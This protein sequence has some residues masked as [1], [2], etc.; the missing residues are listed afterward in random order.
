[1]NGFRRFFNKS[2]KE[3]ES[4]DSTLAELI[5]KERMMGHETGLIPLDANYFKTHVSE[6]IEE[7]LQAVP[8]LTISEELRKQVKIEQQEKEITELKRSELAIQ[9]LQTQQ[10]E[11][12]KNMLEMFHKMSAD[13][14]KFKK[15][16]R[17]FKDED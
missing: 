4:K 16:L 14:E 5:K 6:L 3:S 13:P 7:Y 11:D 10:V 2:L 1:M 17:E 15:L 9:K 8:N 12:R